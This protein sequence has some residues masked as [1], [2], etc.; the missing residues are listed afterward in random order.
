MV[1]IAIVDD[2]KAYSDALE[3]YILQYAGEHNVECSVVKFEDGL[4]FLEKNVCGHDIIF[5]DVEMPYK[6]GFKTAKKIRE[7]DSDVVIVFI[8]NL[9]QY[10]IKGYEVEAMDYIVKPVSYARF[11][12]TFQK[13]LSNAQRNQQE[14]VIVTEKYGKR[15]LP[16]KTIYYIESFGHKLVYHTCSGE[17]ETWDSMSETEQRLKEFGFSRCNNSY[18]VNLRFVDRV[19]GDLIFL[20]DQTLKIGRLKRKGFLD[21]LTQFRL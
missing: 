20:Q 14:R 13:A 5:L 11:K 12:I 9:A 19:E 6:D 21:D 2:D 10:A 15:R 1:R 17:I 18:L 16:I 3:G 8:T 7:A 4:D